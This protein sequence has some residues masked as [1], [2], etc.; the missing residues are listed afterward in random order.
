[1]EQN[2][3]F[4]DRG[5]VGRRT[6]ATARPMH[7]WRNYFQKA[8][9]LSFHHLRRHV[10]V[11]LICAVAYFDPGNWGVDLE[12]GSK[13]G[14]RLLFV[15]LLSGLFAILLQVLASRLGCVTGLDLASH[16]RLLLHSHPTHPLLVRWTLLY[17]LYALS[18]IAIIAT[19]L[20]EL[21]GSAVALCLLFPKLELWHGVLITTCD[22]VFLLCL[23][24]PLRGKP[25]KWFELLIGGLVLSVMVCMCIIISKLNINWGDTF[26]GYLPSKYVFPNGAAYISV[27]II[28]ATIMPHSLFLG[29][30]LATQDRTGVN[31][32]SSDSNTDNILFLTNFLKRTYTFLR[33]SFETSFRVPPPTLK[34]QVNRYADWENNSGQFVK[35]HIYHGTVDIVMS[36][37]GFAVVINSL[38]LILASAVFFYGHVDGAGDAG[39]FDAY[40]LI[41]ELVGP[42]AATIFAFALLFA[43]QSSSIIATVAGQAVAE[44]FIRWRVSPIF[45]RLLTRLI[46]VIPSM[47]VAV[48]LGR[49]GI[50]ALL[51]ASQVVLSIVLPFISFPLVYLTSKK[52]IMC[53]KVPA[54]SANPRAKSGTTNHEDLS[55]MAHATLPVYGGGET[56]GD[57][58]EKDREEKELE[59]QPEDIVLDYSNNLVVTLLAFGIWLVIVVANVYV[60]VTLGSG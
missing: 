57:H 4:E 55:G 54:S 35:S 28:G 38:I 60:I 22:V 46:A 53:V 43:G 15:I 51:V 47:A 58:D 29:S 16:C 14:Y 19:D 49:P 37:L 10:G 9:Y 23:G 41:K 24:D 59:S 33:H 25:L 56:L 45:R 20:A 50:D 36:L 31:S 42:G 1:M 8:V 27:G 5:E 13:F 3:R 6:S 40:D 17:P 30:A 26:E 52:S 44:G 18:E 39:L 32:N 21:L 11:G 12:A 7:A 48:A 2:T 34:E